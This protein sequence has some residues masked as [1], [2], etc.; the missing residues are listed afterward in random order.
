MSNAETYWVNGE[1]FELVF[2][3]DPLVLKPNTEKYWLNGQPVAGLLQ[4]NPDPYTPPYVPPSPTASPYGAETYWL[5]GSPSEMFFPIADTVPPLFSG[6]S[7]L[8][9][10]AVGQLLASWPIAID[11][12]VAPI[13]YQVCIQANTIAGLFQ[14]SNVVISTTQTSC[15]IYAL[16]DGSF[17]EAKTYYVGVRAVDAYGNS[18]TNAVSL[19]AVTAGI[20]IPVAQGGPIFEPRGVFSINPL[21]QLLTIYPMSGISGTD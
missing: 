7:G 14:Q 11:T 2:T 16:P 12:T 4:L 19:G 17:L 3:T 15:S 13:T 10:G 21:N 8:T 5:N 18:D 6:I 20:E 1:P 9:V